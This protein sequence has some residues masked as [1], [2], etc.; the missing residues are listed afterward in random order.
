MLV[1]TRRIEES[2]IIGENIKV[3]IVAIN[4]NSI[5]LGIEAP[6]DIEIVREELYY[7]MK[8]P[9]RRFKAKPV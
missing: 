2:I 7:K 6:R 3:T 5:R 9:L 4:G 8:G 1:L